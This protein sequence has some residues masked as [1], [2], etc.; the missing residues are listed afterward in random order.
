LEGCDIAEAE[1]IIK[2]AK[3]HKGQAFRTQIRGASPLTLPQVKSCWVM[4]RE[5]LESLR[6]LE[7]SLDP[8]PRAV[9]A[10][11]EITLIFDR[12]VQAR[13][14]LVI[15]SGANF[16]KHFL[17]VQAFTPPLPADLLLDLKIKNKAIIVMAAAL[18]PIPKPTTIT[19]KQF[20]SRRQN[21]YFEILEK[22]SVEIRSLKLETIHN[23]FHKAITRCQTF[24]D[25]LSVFGV[26]SDAS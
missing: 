2:F 4:C 18:K 22:S 15:P 3:W 7:N 9:E 20:F 6:H 25:K 26:F 21:Q 16:P 11:K 19:S 12:L 1:L 24:L 17:S 14:A 23:K 5:I 13:D 10:F 8:V